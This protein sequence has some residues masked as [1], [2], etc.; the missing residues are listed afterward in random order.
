M[1]NQSIL[2]KLKSSLVNNIVDALAFC[3]DS[4]V[5]VYEI[6]KDTVYVSESALEKFFLPGTQFSNALKQ[7]LP[8]LQEEDKVKFLQIADIISVNNNF[9]SKGIYNIFDSDGLP[10]KIEISAKTITDNEQSYVVGTFQTVKENLIP[11]EMQAEHDFQIAHD[12]NHS[13]NGFLL[14]VSF[15][16]FTQHNTA[17]SVENE[18]HEMLASAC[19]T[20]ETE[21]TKVYELNQNAFLFMN[22]SEGNANSIRQIYNDLRQEVQSIELATNYQYLFTLAAGGIVLFKETSDM[23]SLSQKLMF[24][25]HAAQEQKKNTLYLFSNQ[26]Y[27]HY[28]HKQALENSLRLSLKDNA[29]DFKLFFQPIVDAK[30]AIQENHEVDILGAEALL[31]YQNPKGEILGA[32]DIIPVLEKSG[33]I[34][35][36]GRWILL[37]AFQQCKAWNTLYPNFSISV[38]VSHIQLANTNLVNEVQLA[39][40]K[41]GVNPKNVILELTES[42]IIDSY[43]LQSYIEELTRLGLQVDID[44]FGT[45]FSNLRYIQNLHVDTLKLD[46]SFIHKAV[47]GNGRD[48]KIIEYVTKMAHDLGISVCM[49]G[50]ESYADVEK[51]KY[52]EPDR[53]QG[54]LFG[55]PLPADRFEREH[56]R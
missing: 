53:F 46:Y 29:Q 26:N 3:T 30:K 52:I 41:T 15:L 23:S 37:N 54:F 7:I 10:C 56:F 28:T 16:T 9:S 32:N 40:A 39:L 18:L 12:K 45:G 20:Q 24:A 36:V 27:V 35:P 33:L 31:R 48:L 47:I 34:I 1:E 22:L 25:L 55:K 43:E 11:T 19:K 4:H 21:T 13:L 38:N 2:P 42:G 44:D 51:L 6:L 50:I 5:F 17:L 49:E 8:F 14:A